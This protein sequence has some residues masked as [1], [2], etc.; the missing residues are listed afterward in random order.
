MR[1]GTLMDCNLKTI[2]KS[3]AD[4]VDDKGEN[5]DGDDDNGEQIHQ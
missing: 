3:K 5:V 2:D 1:P 4:E